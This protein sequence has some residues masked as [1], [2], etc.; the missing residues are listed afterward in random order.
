M[1]MP[2]Q[3]RNR[4]PAAI[5]CLASVL[6]CVPAGA[7]SLP[8][9]EAGAG[10]AAL[11]LPD[12]RGADQHTAYVLPIP[13]FVYR[14][15]F[16]KADRNG[17]RGTLF[18]NDKVELNL[19]LNGTLPVNSR[20]NLARS[21]M[22]NLKPTVE[23]GANLSINLWQSATQD[24]K[25]DFR[26]PIR[27][28]VTV[29]SSP[30]QIG[31]RFAPNLNLDIKNPAGLPGWNLGILAGPLFDSRRYNA[32]FYAVDPSQATATRPVYTASGGYSGAQATLA[33]SKRYAGTWVGG[34]LRYDTL[35]GAVFED[36][37]LVRQ[38]SAVSA[39]VAVTWI[40]GESATRVQADE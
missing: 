11:R 2:I 33:L 31:W 16:L 20:D 8:L 13:Y 34:F 21:G 14:G 15:E 17:V 6:S 23:L 36:S 7:A 26:A 39:G 10:I 35:A 28:A 24:F 1:K 4:L 32:Y 22:R 18:D 38:R 40:F 19:S 29:E 3:C 25:L 12:Y 30:Q 5:A 27:T 9:W 37:P